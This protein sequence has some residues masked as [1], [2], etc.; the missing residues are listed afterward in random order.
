MAVDDTDSSEGMC[1][2][3]LLTEIIRRVGLDVIGYPRLVRLN[4]NIKYKTRGNGALNVRLGKGSGNKVSIG[5]IGDKEIFSYENGTEYSDI[6]NLM[7]IAKQIV[8]EIS[9]MSEPNTNPGIVISTS[10]PGPELYRNALNEELSLDFAEKFLK[11]NRMAY[12][13]IKKGRGIIGAAA[14]L[15]WPEEK[16]TYESI[17]YIYPHPKAV[18]KDLKIRAASFVDSFPDTFNN[19]D[20]ANQYAAIFPKARTPVMYGIRGTDPLNLHR[21]GDLLNAEFSIKPERQITFLTNQGTDDHILEE[22]AE[23]RELGSYS[24]TGRITVDPWSIEG[25]H[26]FSVMEYKGTMV[27]IAAFEPTKE[28]RRIFSRLRRGDLI[29]VAG[30]Y[31]NST[32]NVEKLELLK[33]AQYF[34]R[35]PPTCKNC[36]SRMKT[37][38]INDFRCDKCGSRQN[39]PEYTEETRNIDE[40]RYEVPVIAR[41]HLSMPLKLES[42]FALRNAQY[43]REE[44]RS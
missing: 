11:R 36:G 16:V 37:K 28:F 35:M 2:T 32:L 38:G 44:I 1:T 19:I 14:S 24:I 3:Y 22:P 40:G 33:R 15:S 26:Y 7:E 10:R 31:V 30:S 5:N 20:Y 9:V 42:H 18:P 29:S 43:L 8:E 41:R 17:S 12:A 6:S 13:K 25:G 21:I 27:K 34:S 4:P 39:L 23:I